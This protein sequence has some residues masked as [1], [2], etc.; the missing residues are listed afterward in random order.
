VRGLYVAIYRVASRA[1]HA[2]PETV[3]P[4]AVDKLQGYPVSIDLPL[5]AEVSDGRFWCE[6][7]GP[8]FSMALLVHNEQFGKPEAARVD[9]L[10]PAPSLAGRLEEPPTGTA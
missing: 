7:A 2:Q 5:E 9:P 8:L 10:T 4:Y 3:D 6:V 1:V